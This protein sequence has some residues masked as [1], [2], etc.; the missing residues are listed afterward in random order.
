MIPRSYHSGLF[1]HPSLGTTKKDWLRRVPGGTPKMLPGLPLSI[2][3]SEAGGC[4][5]DDAEVS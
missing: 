1:M 4:D 3:L 5:D 2:V